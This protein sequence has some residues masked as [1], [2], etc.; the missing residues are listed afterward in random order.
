MNDF[1]N[2]LEISKNKEDSV[3]GMKLADIKHYS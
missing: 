3:A 2:I 1:S